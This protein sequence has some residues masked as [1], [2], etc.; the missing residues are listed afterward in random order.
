MS[1][2]V[3]VKY[4]TESCYESEQ[5]PRKGANLEGLSGSLWVP[6]S[7]FLPKPKDMLPM[8][9][10]C[11]WRVLQGAWGST[12]YQVTGHQLPSVLSHSCW[13]LPCL[14]LRAEPLSNCTGVLALEGVVPSPCQHPQRWLDGWVS[15]ARCLPTQSLTEF[16]ESTEKVEQPKHGCKATQHACGV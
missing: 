11:N 2:D 16:T 1:H 5:L 6:G 4:A 15:Q 9:Q 14:Q 13:H 12:A 7:F 10:G 3:T 8:L